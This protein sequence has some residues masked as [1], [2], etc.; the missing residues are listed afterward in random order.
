[1]DYR[2]IP[3]L[4]FTDGANARLSGTENR[5]RRHDFVLDQWYNP[6]RFITNSMSMKRMANRIALLFNVGRQWLTG[7]P[8]YRGAA[9]CGVFAIGAMIAIGY[10]ANRR[11]S[12]PSARVG[13]TSDVVPTRDF[14]NS[15]ESFATPQSGKGGPLARAIASDKAFLAGDSEKENVAIRDKDKVKKAAKSSAKKPQ[16]S[17]TSRDTDRGFNPLREI[18]RVLKKLEE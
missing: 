15:N 9:I 8:R 10:N 3:S 11:V 18:Q 4:Q 13:Q 2:S 16:R 1:M 14:A 12:P 17:V 7:A 6:H 5:H